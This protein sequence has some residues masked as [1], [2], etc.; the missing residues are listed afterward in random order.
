MDERRMAKM[1][2]NKEVEKLKAR[3]DKELEALTKDLQNVL[4]MYKNE[5]IEFKLAPKFEF[6][7]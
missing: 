7:C 4:D 3:H 5:E 6:Y 1:K 2:Q